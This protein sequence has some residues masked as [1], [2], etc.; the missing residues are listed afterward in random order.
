MWIW[1]RIV[2]RLFRRGECGERT[3]VTREGLYY[4]GLMS[5]IFGLA[6]VRQINLVLVLAGMMVGPLIVNRQLVARTLRKL[7]VRRVAPPSI[8][9]GDLLVVTL[10]LTNQRR[11]LSSWGVT[12]ADQLQRE[13]AGAE[14]PPLVPESLVTYVP[15]QGAC[16]VVY[17]CRL[18]RRG[19]YR[20]GPIRLSTGFPFGLLRRT[21]G[22]ASPQS[23]YVYPRLGLLTRRW[24]LRHREDYEGSQRRERRS[25]VASGDFYG[26]RPW[27][28]GDSRRWIHWRS[29]ARRGQV[30]VRQFERFRNRDVA[31]LVDLWQPHAASREQEENVELAVSFAASVIADLCRRGGG[32][33]LLGLSGP[34]PQWIEGPASPALLDDVMQRLAV[35]G[36]SPDDHLPQLLQ[37]ALKR[38]D[39]EVQVVLVSTRPV[40]VQ[41]TQ[42]LA[43]LPGS[44][45]WRSLLGRMRVIDAASS[46]LEHYFRVE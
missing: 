3:I 7:G 30:V 26:V 16:T 6:M 15:P 32:D 36:A 14:E 10:E 18:P 41:D 37:E 42:R 44:P 33:L 2:N 21:V 35:A 29:T 8:C 23:L 45:A 25:G 24:L 20:F 43:D 19:R 11:R 1:R 39:T 5:A 46:E 38:I 13:D 9:A 34:T 12:V 28:R 17:R 22:C 31:V 4:L 40:D 27:Q